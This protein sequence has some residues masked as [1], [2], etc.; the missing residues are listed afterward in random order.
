MTKAAA[1]KAVTDA[2]TVLDG[3]LESAKEA[4][5]ATEESAKSAATSDSNAAKSE[6]AAKTSETNAQSH[7][8]AAAKHEVAAKGYAGDAE[9][10]AARAGKIA[11]STSWDGDRLTVNGKTSPPLT[12]KQGETGPQGERGPKGEQGETGPQGERGPKGE[13]GETGP[14]GE[15]GT[16]TWDGIT[17]KPN[18]ATKEELDTLAAQIRTADVD[19]R[20][21]RKLNYLLKALN[22]LG[23]THFEWPAKPVEKPVP[24]DMGDYTSMEPWLSLIHIS[25]PTRLL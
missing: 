6:K 25:E 7:A 19:P 4:R 1:D 5:D 24:Q 12:G 20:V 13:Q 15:R 8:S 11:E 17:D 18:V 2:Q 16:T 22:S 21:T 23:E 3:I 10:A 9:K 14:A